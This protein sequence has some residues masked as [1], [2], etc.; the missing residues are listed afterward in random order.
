M[1]KLT[2]EVKELE[3]ESLDKSY[4]FDLAIE[5][6]ERELRRLESTITI[7]D[8][9]NSTAS[10]GNTRDASSCVHNVYYTDAAYIIN[11][12]CL[13]N[14]A[15]KC[16]L[17]NAQRCQTPSKDVEIGEKIDGMYVTAVFCTL[18][19]DS[20]YQII[21]SHLIKDDKG[22]YCKCSKIF[23]ENAIEDITC[24]MNIRTCPLMHSALNDYCTAA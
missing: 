3:Q 11:R 4:F 17:H 22:T 5:N 20:P 7:N 14:D 12:T 8:S 13:V 1:A 18:D 23:Q 2:A 9:T 24:Q 16:T 21:S 6:V 19:K 10:S 15:G